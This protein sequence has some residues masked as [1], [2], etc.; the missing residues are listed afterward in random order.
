MVVN[1][2]RVIV[3][4]TFCLLC[5][6]AFKWAKTPITMWPP[7]QPA[8]VRVLSEFEEAFNR[9]HAGI[10]LNAEMHPV[11]PCARNLSSPSLVA[12]HQIS[13]RLKN[14]APVDDH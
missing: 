8:G 13:L 3:V 6:L 2:K 5:A 4:A 9:D 11:T 7:S 12:S 1:G 10:Q 14:D